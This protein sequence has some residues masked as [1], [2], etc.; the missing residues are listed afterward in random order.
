VLLGFRVGGLL[1]GARV[2]SD[3]GLIVGF[4]VGSTV[5]LTVGPALGAV[6][7]FAEGSKLGPVGA[8]VGT[9]C[10]EKY[11]VYSSLPNTLTTPLASCALTPLE[12]PPV[13]LEPQVTTAPS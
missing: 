7:G 11:C 10:G 12:S 8:M 6:E 4:A 13:V 5:G 9:S 3:V 2:G 1:D